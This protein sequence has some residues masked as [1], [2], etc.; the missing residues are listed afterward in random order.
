M[1][2]ED[3]RRLVLELL[4]EGGM[5]AELPRAGVLTIGSAASKVGFTVSG[6]GVSDV[7]C[8]IGR[9]KGGG[10]ALK[11]LG[12]EYGTWVNGERVQQAKLDAGDV[13]LVGSRRLRVVDPAAPTT[14][15]TTPAAKAPAAA[16]PAVAAA[17]LV[18]TS[19]PAPAPV[20]SAPVVAAAS[21]T[22]ITETPIPK[23][24]PKPSIAATNYEQTP[25]PKIPGYRIEK[26]LGRGGMGEVFLATQE[27]LDRKV[28]LKLLS[29]KLCADADFVRRFKDEARAAAALTHPN[30]VVVHDVGEEAGRHYLSM[31]FM[32]KGNLEQRV[33]RGARMGWIEVLG[34]LHDMASA[35]VYAEGRGI[36][37]R[38]LKPANMMQGNAGATKL[39]DLGLATQLEAEASE[40][41]NGRIFGTPHFISPEQ[42]RGERVDSR[43]DLYSLGATAYRLL[44]G[45]T[46][47]EGATT[48]DILRGHF[49]ETPKS[50][51][52]IDPELP[53]D[54]V[55]IIERLLQKK[56]EDRFPS[57]AVL[58]KE[59]DRVRA[60]LLHADVAQQSAGG[61]PK[62]MVAAAAL[63]LLGGAAWW[64][65]R[66]PQGTVP[67]P[68][69]AHG[70]S[71]TPTPPEATNEDPGQVPVKPQPIRDDDTQIKLRETQ[72]KLAW[73]E[74]PSDLGPAERATR[75][76]QLVTEF[77]GTTA[78]FDMQAEAVQI[79][80]TLTRESAATAEATARRSTMLQS[81]EAAALPYANF[82]ARAFEAL[83]AIPL[84]PEL[85]ADPQ[86]MKS[87]LE[88]YQHS[89][90]SALR[91]A[92]AAG[93]EIDA[94]AARGDF[95][96][97]R[98][99]VDALM[100][101]LQQPNLPADIDAAALPDLEAMKAL[102]KAMSE[103]R[104]GIDSESARFSSVQ[105][106]SDR[107]RV[108]AEL[109]AGG[110]FQRELSKLDFAALHARL[111]G[112]ESSLST[113]PARALVHAIDQ[114]LTRGKAALHN[115]AAE[116]SGW[117]RKQVMDPRGGRGTIRNASAI[118]DSGVTFDVDGKS[119][120]LPWS[121]FGSR[122]R[123]LHFLFNERLTR[124]YT[125]DELLGI[126]ALIRTAAVSFAVDCAK[127]MF[128]PTAGA[129]FDEAEVR[130][131]TEAFEWGREWAKLAGTGDRYE[132]ESKAGATLAK[133]LSDASQ[134]AWSASVAGLDRLLLEFRDTLLVRMISDGKT[135]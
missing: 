114:D 109:E 36:V 117:K 58:L 60:N 12:S 106:E 72:A 124:A 125:A 38:D 96:D 10:F 49:F 81:L 65:T 79:R 64:F 73:K 130:E 19:I 94:S 121:S 133:S 100:P 1:S 86:F 91:S 112:L 102:A 85:T 92:Q 74:L 122:P 56:P 47:F 4:G 13:I 120:T 34:V 52:E 57:A 44:S 82:V 118:D 113:E 116:F 18:Q 75:L 51:A 110:N 77:A 76:D 33:A 20:K 104:A 90:A 63:L 40:S 98:K 2:A 5:Q 59:V 93:A 11:D 29:V 126:E 128:D 115:V 54:L 9:A 111:A 127:E 27:R 41:E 80:A 89:L 119:E 69:L 37:H 31:E 6:Q 7:H 22:P 14:A 68:P 97:V 42:A 62:S 30:V 3:N 123:E 129:R 23:A 78:A 84:A 108:A 88:I 35:L 105:V 25:L 95:A 103:R 45:R 15:A 66:S 17:P 53:P 107:Q 8:A 134:G 101:I 39:A 132:R 55:R 32:D 46:P 99:R 26:L 21:L 71:T 24:T 67:A 61:I 16:A 48:R 87:R 131:L 50:L 70:P 43:A 83:N 28:A 135:N